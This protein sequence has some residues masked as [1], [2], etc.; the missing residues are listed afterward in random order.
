[1]ATPFDPPHGRFSMVSCAQSR[2]T[3]Y[4]LAPLLTGGGSWA[5]NV[6]PA[7][8]TRINAIVSRCMAVLPGQ[9]AAKQYSSPA[10][11]VPTRFSAEQPFDGCAEFHGEPGLP[12]V[13]RSWCPTVALPA[14]LLVQ[15]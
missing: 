9:S 15:F 7:D 12:K 1:M 8:T 4:G 6:A 3:R 2:M 5:R 11:P 13:R 10:P 14:P